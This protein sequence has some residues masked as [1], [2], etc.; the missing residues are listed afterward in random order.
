MGW[1]QSRGPAWDPEAQTEHSSPDAQRRRLIHLGGLP[2]GGLI[3]FLCWGLANS[4]AKNRALRAPPARAARGRCSPGC[5]ST[6][7][8][9]RAASWDAAS[10]HPSLGE[11]TLAQGTLPAYATKMSRAGRWPDSVPDGFVPSVTVSWN[12]PCLTS[13]PFLSWSL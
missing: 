8:A 7:R 6:S 2:R 5:S 11:T 9:H 3:A 1:D 4:P 13:R 10:R 12:R